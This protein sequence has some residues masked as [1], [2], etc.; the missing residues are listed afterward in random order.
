MSCK[1]RLVP[2][3]WCLIL[4]RSLTI[5]INSKIVQAI[6]TQ[7]WLLN[8]QVLRK[9]FQ[10][11]T[12]KLISSCQESRIT[13]VTSLFEARMKEKQDCR[14]DGRKLN[15]RGPVIWESARPRAESCLGSQSPPAA[16]QDG[17]E[18]LESCSRMGVLLD[19]LSQCVQ[20]APGQMASWSVPKQCVQ[21]TDWPLCH[22]FPFI[23]G[24]I[25]ASCS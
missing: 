20:G 6:S 1:M 14:R 21:C 16:L 5:F 23:P 18:W 9:L 4:H 10:I 24:S 25:H 11:K 8:W 2:H 12:R 19:S 15:R 17:A 7:I 22:F 3:Y 13:F